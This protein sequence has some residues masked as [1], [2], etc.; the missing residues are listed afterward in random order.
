[1]IS[2]DLGNLIK[3]IDLYIYCILLSGRWIEWLIQIAYY[4]IEFHVCN[5]SW[6]AK[7]ARSDE[8]P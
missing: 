2:S 3:S 5:L 1:M 8:G 4:I 7:E 6:Y